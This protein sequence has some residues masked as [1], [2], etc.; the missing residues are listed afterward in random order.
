[1]MNY[2]KQSVLGIAFAG[3]CVIAS[4]QGPAKEDVPNG[5][6]LLDQQKNG[7]YGISLDRA[8]DFLKNKKSKTVI[9]AVIDS[10]VDTTHEDLKSILWTN[11]KEIPGNGIDDDGNGYVDDIHGWNFLGGKDARN[12][13]ED[14]YE[15]ARV[16]YKY[17][18]K[19]Q[20]IKD[21][22]SLSKVDRYDYNMWRKAKQQVEADG[23]DKGAELLI[24]RRTYDAASKSDSI[25]KKALNKDRYTGT[26]LQAY[27]PTTDEAKRA[28]ATLLY[29]F[30]AGNNMEMTNVDFMSDFNEYLTSERKKAEALSTP[31]KDYRGEIVK[32][33]YNDIND[34][35]YGNPDIMAS[36]ALHGTHVSGIIAAVR[37]NGVGID[38]IADN[39]RI[40][41]VRAVP[42]GDEHDK[43]IANA[44]RYAVDNGA[45]VINMS[46]GKSFSP[47]KKWVDDAV[48]YAQS[49]G[50]LLVHA[51]VNE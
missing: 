18:D 3:F 1:M 51:A 25:L 12:V 35:Y 30:Q 45:R 9:V 14:S 36:T 4:A 15:V 21:P 37:G 24:L 31:P 32:D 44:I 38:G 23:K 33:N 47:E 10:G 5:W 39:V 27:T 34:R 42:D 46:F 17:K 19:F 29:F 43:D 26:E 7:Y 40:M 48:K 2:F 8:Y 11:T 49:K 13:S 50:L 22:A 20:N 41:M 6:H 16:Y 28:K